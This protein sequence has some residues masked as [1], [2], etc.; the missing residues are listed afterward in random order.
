MRPP[1]GTVFVLRL[2]IA[3]ALVVITLGLGA[4]GARR[5]AHGGTLRLPTA[6]PISSLDPLEVTWPAEALLTAL[7]YDAPYRLE[8]D[9]HARP[10][11]LYPVK[12]LG[13]GRTLRFKVRPHAVFHGGRAVRASHVLDGLR[14]LARSE[15]QGWLLAMVDGGS[16]R[17]RAEAISLVGTNSIQIRLASARNVDLLVHALSAPQAGIA[18]SRRQASSGVGSGPFIHRRRRRGERVLRANRDYFDGPPY[19]NEVRLL[20][21]IDRDDHIRHFQLGRADASLLGDSVY[22]E[23]PPITGTAQTVGPPVNQVHLLF[24]TDRG[25][26]RQL[27]LRRGVDLALDRRRIAGDDA[28][29]LQF[30]GTRGPARSDPGRARSIFRGL[31]LSESSRPLVL[32]VE[33]A[34]ATGVA[35]APLIQRDLSAAGLPVE[36]VAASAGEARRRLATGSW[37]LRLQTVSPVS[38]DEVLVRAQLLALGGME[39]EAARLVARAPAARGEELSRAA[40]LLTSTLPLIPICVRRPRLHH[41]INLRGVRYDQLGRLAVADLWL[42]S[43]GR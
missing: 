11:L 25:P 12:A 19:L 4:L 34:D 6:S 32:L 16:G 8:A 23:R 39:A 3:A 14:R 38:V 42:R 24:N 10:H 28:E 43:A 35:L 41:R 7:L 22:G 15:R 40:A 1:G 2:S 26:S 36:R 20:T 9:G 33:E 5:P 21:S 18:P 29:P 13:G 31:G 17:E 30:P 27:P 37:D